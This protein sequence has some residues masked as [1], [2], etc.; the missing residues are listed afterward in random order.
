MTGS[1]SNVHENL[2]EAADPNPDVGPNPY[3]GP[4]PFEPGEVLYGREKDVTELYYLWNAERIVVLCSPS[5]AGKSSLI[6]AGLLP[7][8]RGDLDAW[9]PTRVNLEPAVPG[10]NRYVLSALQGLEEGVPESMRRPVEE[11]ARQTLADYVKTR[12]RRRSAP[13]NIALLFDQFEEILTVDPLAVDEKEEFF[14][15]LGELLHNSRIWALFALRE[16]YLAALDPYAQRVPTHLSNRFRMD[17]LSLDGARQAILGPARVGG[18]SFPAVDRMVRDL[19]TLKVQQPDGSF[20]EQ[21]G[22]HVEPVQLQV[23]CFR[24]W[25]RLPK[26]DRE[27]HDEHLERFGDVTEALAGYYA[28]SVARVCRGE[29]LAQNETD[30]RAVREWFDEVLITPSG[31]RSQVLRGSAESGGLDN[32][33]VE[34]LL[35]THLVRAEKRTG[36]TWYELAHDRLIQGVKSSNQDWFAENLSDVQ[37]RST[38]W[39]RQGRPSGLLMQDEDLVLGRRW[40][41]RNQA[42]LTDVERFYLEA[43]EAAQKVIDRDR[44]QRKWIRRLFAASILVSLVAVMMGMRAKSAETKARGAEMKALET[45]KVATS[46]SRLKRSPTSARLVA[47]E[48]EDP[49]SSAD[50][51]SVLYAT[52]SASHRW[53]ILRGHE[54]AV[55]TAVFSPDGTRVVTGSSD[56]TVKIWNAD[57]GREITV[58]DA[59]HDDSVVDVTF[60]SDGSRFLTRSLDRT[61][62]LWEGNS[63]ALTRVVRM[64]GEILGA[65][66]GPQGPLALVHPETGGLSVWDL[67]A[68]REIWT[69][70]IQLGPTPRFAV[71]QAAPRLVLHPVAGPAQIWDLEQGRLVRELEAT[72]GS[73]GASFFSADGSLLLVQGKN[74]RA[75]SHDPSGVTD[76]GH[77]DQKAF[78]SWVVETGSDAVRFEL[79]HGE[80]VQAAIFSRDNGHLILASGRHIDVRDAAEGTP[81]HAVDLSQRVSM[82]TLSPDQ[83]RFFAAE[84]ERGSLWDIKTG[85]RIAEFQGHGNQI[86]TARFN[87]DGSRI[88]TASRDGT[89]RIWRTEDIDVL[90]GRAAFSADSRHLVSVFERAIR[91]WDVEGRRELESEEHAF[92]AED[93]VISPDGRRVAKLSCSVAPEVCV[94]DLARERKGGVLRHGVG[95]VQ[96]VRFDPADSERLAVVGRRRIELHRLS[97]GEPSASLVVEQAI[98]SASFNAAGSRLLVIPDA[99]DGTGGAQVWDGVDAP[100]LLDGARFPTLGSLSPDGSLALVGSADLKANHHVAEL[101]D[102]DTG[103]RL[104]TLEGHTSELHWVAFHPDGIHLATASEDGTA[105]LWHPD[106]RSVQELSDHGGPVWGASFN[107]D[108]SKLVTASADRT[109]IL[110]RQER[111]GRK[112]VYIKVATLRGHTRSVRSARFSAD[113]WWILTHS[114]DGTSRLWPNNTDLLLGLNRARTHSCLEAPFRQRKLNESA[115]RARVGEAACRSCVERFFDALDGRKTAPAYIEAWHVYAQCLETDHKQSTP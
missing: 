51:L 30:E 64:P 43:C 36:A 61:V 92:G 88:V 68:H 79:L 107:A 57:N 6:H 19:A 76:T 87:A 113:G 13:K 114:R 65:R 95:V 25:D 75:S 11:L 101:F 53:V 84:A 78:K 12:P 20:R 8:T 103:R 85:R 93:T 48:A 108:G 29:T 28:D 24:L 59:K 35:D 67:D 31:V 115:A 69:R 60:S 110:W 7:R 54:G 104:A 17:L 89:A 34:R 91:V 38:L 47:L 63:G 112:P 81:R 32:R 94:W 71:A 62:R 33:L 83:E 10:V 74:P 21:T 37:Q 55:K 105:R 80:P 14:D 9:G 42:K 72:V 90:P 97:V 77:H 1:A 2:S 86:E 26:E 100:Q 50:I 66:F 27:I 40:A 45:L 82:L 16:D 41:E 70:S 58:A 5:G 44:L 106:G 22:H 23:T 46:Q 49:E 111:R 39:E 56:N 3:V 99:P 15:Q 73:T 4:R 52:L 18:R 102:A 98:G 96:D 109:A